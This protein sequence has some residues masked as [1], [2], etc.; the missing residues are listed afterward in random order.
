GFVVLAPLIVERR[1]GPAEP[2]TIVR[3]VRIS[4]AAVLI[5][6]GAAYAAIA[7]YEVRG[8]PIYFGLS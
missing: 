8:A 4:A 2:A 6:F 7:V 3:R 5:V 1:C